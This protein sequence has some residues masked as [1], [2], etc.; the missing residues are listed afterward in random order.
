MLTQA[1]V[2]PSS[3]LVNLIWQF[4]GKM[5]GLKESEW[6]AIGVKMM[7]GTLLWTIGPPAARLY[8]VEPVGVEMISLY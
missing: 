8:A 4:S 7:A 1:E 2:R 3:G 5:R 6:G